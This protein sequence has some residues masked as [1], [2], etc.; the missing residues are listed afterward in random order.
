M[1]VFEAAAQ[2]VHEDLQE[3]GY[4][5]DA[6]GAI[7][8]DLHLRNILF[9][10]GRVGVVDFDLCGLGHYLFDL[11]VLLN[12]LRLSALRSQR[13]DRFWNMRETFFEHYERECLLSEGYRRYLMMFHA[14]RHVARASTGSFAPSARKPTAAGPVALTHYAT[15]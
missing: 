3:L 10:S 5:R 7:H 11:A 13:P 14:M 15:W 1:A 2:R 8:R 12:A 9:H 4:D 6:F